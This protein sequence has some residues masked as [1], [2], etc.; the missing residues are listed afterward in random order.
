MS[1]KQFSGYLWTRTG[2]GNGAMSRA[3]LLAHCS[4]AVRPRADVKARAYNLVLEL[5]GKGEAEDVA[6]LLEDREGIKALM[7]ATKGDPEDVTQER[8]PFII[9]KVKLAA[10]EFAAGKVRTEKDLE[11]EQKHIEYKNNLEIVKQEKEDSRVLLE[12]KVAEKDRILL[13]ENQDKLNLEAQNMLL[14]KQLAERDNVNLLRRTNVE[15]N[16][17]NKAV[18]TYHICRWVI[19]IVFAMLTFYTALISSDHPIL[20]AL[21]AALLGF[22]GFW[23]IPDLFGIWLNKIAYRKYKS[24][25]TISDP[26]AVISAAI[27]DFSKHIGA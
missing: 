4:A 22:I 26:D 9:E 27:P 14:K 3:R 10:G 13:Q 2:G 5:N 18:D 21:L 12:S 8:L 11:L 7:R 6:A 24:E 17:H 16:A 20:S 1:D 15:K 23:F 25:I 19:A